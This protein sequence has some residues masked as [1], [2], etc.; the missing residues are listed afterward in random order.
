M[1]GMKEILKPAQE[2]CYNPNAHGKLSDEFAVQIQPQF[3][4]PH[5]CIFP[6]VRMDRNVPV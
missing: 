3:I 4:A 5:L 2:F 1:N 6:I